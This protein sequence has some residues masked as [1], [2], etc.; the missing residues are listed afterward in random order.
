MISNG[1]QDFASQYST[2]ADEEIARLA[3]QGGLRPE[4]EIAVK[5]EMQRRSISAEDVRSLRL[6]DKRSQ[7]QRR[8][9]TNPN[10]GRGTRLE[11]RGQKFFN[12][13]DERKGISTVTRWFVFSYMPLIPLGS[14]RVRASK[15]DDLNPQ[16]IG[17]IKLQWDQ[18]WDGWKKTA[19]IV[20]LV[21]IFFCGMV[22]WSRYRN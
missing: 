10:L 20:S 14:Y 7:L 6:R 21:V 1:Q 19:V 3:S 11:F 2:L 9:G 17:K 4:A 5:V 12:E 15:S 22:L 8:V 18:V 13:H 16:I